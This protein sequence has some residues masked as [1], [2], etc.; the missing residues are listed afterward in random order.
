MASGLGELTRARA[1]DAVAE[2]L[3]LAANAPSSGKKVAKQANKMAED[4]VTAAQAN[5]ELLR[6]LVRS[7]IDAALERFD[8][9]RVLTELGSLGE[10]VRALRTQVEGLTL[11][12]LEKG[13][14]AVTAASTV[15]AQVTGAG[16]TGEPRAQSPAQAAPAKEAPV[17]K[18]A[19]VKEAPVKKAAPAKKVAPS[20]AAPTKKAA[21]AEKV[22][23]AKKAPAKKAP[24][25][26]ASPAKK[27]AAG[28]D[29]S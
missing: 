9:G 15:A 6:A 16:E 8:L 5:R 4:V 2:V 28:P 11:V 20:K 19:P 17:K 29:Q 24:A 26:K 14:A 27:A 23:P 1:A 3:T 13:E 25:K 22:A 18:V 10:S 12:A 21:P 7:E